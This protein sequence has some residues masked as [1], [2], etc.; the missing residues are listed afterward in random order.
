MVI[1]TVLPLELKL[2]RRR[3]HV[4]G[5]V[6][7]V[8]FRPFVFHLAERFGISG[9]VLNNAAGVIIEAEGN[10][11]A[12][13]NFENTLRNDAPPLAH[14]AHISSEWLPALGERT[15]RIVP[16]TNNEQKRAWISP[17]ASVCDD[18]LRE[19]FDPNNRRYRYPFINCTS[20]GPRFTI[21]QDVPYD[22]LYT[23]MAEFPMCADCQREYDDPRDR[24]FHAQPNA[25]ARC[26]PQV[27]LETNDERRKTT[28]TPI[29]QVAELFF[30]GKI[31]AV[32]GL[33][34]Y[35]LACDAMNDEAVAKLRAR[36][37][38]NEKPF[39]LMVRDLETA[40]ALCE[41]NQAEEKLLTS[42]RRP[43]VL[44]RAHKTSRVSPHVAPKQNT[45]GIMLPY[46]P[47]HHLLLEKSPPALVMTSGNVSDEP[48][49]FR[50]DEARERLSD[51]ADAFLTH[52][53]VIHMRCDDSVTRVVNVGALHEMPLRR[54]RG[55]VPEPLRAPQR[56]H[57]P[58][59]A[60]GAH[61]K[62]TFCLAKDDYA[63]VS[64][65]IGDLEN[66]E[67]L[68][69]FTHGIEH[70]KKL[71]DLEPRII[72]YDLHPE[73]LSTKYALEQCAM[74][75]LQFAMPVQHHHAHIASVMGEHGI[76]ERVIGVAF[77]GTGYGTDGTLWGGEFLIADLK[78]FERAA[79]LDTIPLIGGEQAIHEVWRLAAAWLDKIYGDDF[80]DLEID[81]VKRLERAKWRVMK[82]MLANNVNTPRT[83]AMGRLFDAVA[84]LIGV[85]DI[86]TY[87]AQAAIELEM[88]AD[89]N[90]V[91]E[92][93]FEISN[94]RPRLLKMD[95]T[96]RAIVHDLQNGISQNSI[97]A[98]FHNT[99]A[100]CI[101]R[102]CELLRAE[103]E[104][105]R[106]VLGGGVFQ[107]TR[108]LQ[109]TG[110]ALRAKNF[111]TYVPTKLPPNDGGI[112]FGQALVANAQRLAAD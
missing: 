77:D 3:I 28:D 103:T 88:L 94:A 70:F 2:E 51:I 17:D 68:L 73:Y 61:L 64:H 22:R 63:F 5:I 107:N 13:D 25:C 6:Q 55:A 90:C 96:C 44:L 38:R 26:G 65:H 31:V 79:H 104:L 97:A 83:S 14:V 99:I 80:L 40:R 29:E 92:Y 18:C 37:R 84:A 39:A 69:S 105:E 62:N 100:S 81:F 24:R 67:T 86:A 35:H 9:W 108:L 87:E 50:D 23:T 33:G 106:V 43:I 42:R 59:L 16:S 1:E 111:Q 66:Y 82:Q 27:R 36:K 98:K 93:P 46:T 12:L 7:G 49:A 47:L 34:G 78:S 95:A 54:S 72:A 112:S 52:N 85:R 76:T 41:I 74:R 48:I 110:R 102:T 11:D 56:L 30:E 58:I 19:L 8:G 91:Q 4:Q 60:V 45:L 53:R 75:H 10:A 109:Q 89:E 32:K 20:C 101:A 15:F 57:T 71:F 21:V